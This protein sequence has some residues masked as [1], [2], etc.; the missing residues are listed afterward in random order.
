VSFP[1]TVTVAADSVTAQT[2]FVVNRK[3]FGIVYP[4]MPDDLIQD[5]VLM[6]ISFVAKRG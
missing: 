1:A 4:G 6:K 5:N 3:D 2:E